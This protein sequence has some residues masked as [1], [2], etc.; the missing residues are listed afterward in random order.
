[1]PVSSFGVKNVDFGGISSPVSA[2]RRISSR[3]TGRMR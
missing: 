3:E 2:V 1:M